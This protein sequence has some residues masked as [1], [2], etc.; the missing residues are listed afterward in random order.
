LNSPSGISSRGWAG[1]G[2]LAAVGLFGCPRAA[3]PAD[4]V[5]L[6][7]ESPPETLDR[8][9]ALS[10]IAENLSGNLLEPGLVR[11][12]DHG[13]PVPDLAE[14]FE[15]LD[16][17]TYLFTLRPGLRFH[18]GSP[19]RSADVVASFESLLDPR[20]ASPLAV[21]FQGLTFTAVGDLQVRVKLAKPYAPFLVDMQMGIVPARAQAAPGRDDFGQHPIGAGPFRF[22]SWVDEERLLLEA[23]PDYYGG[24]PAIAHL[25][26]KTVRDETTRVLEL[27]SG[28]ADIAINAISPPLLPELE[29][30]PN[31]RVLSTPGADVLFLMFQLT[32][33]QVADPRV[34]QALA[35]AIDRE[36]LIRYKFFGHAE[37]ADSL[38]PPASWAHA[39]GLPVYHRDLAK[40][41]ALLD[42]A[43]FPARAGA[44]R[45]TL[46]YKTS[47]DRFRKSI[48]LAIAQQL[49]EV[50][51]EVRV[52]TLE[53]GTFFS[54]IR[55]GSFELASM[56]WVPIVEP[57]LLYWVFDSASIPTPENGYNG[58]N[59][60][61]FR[62]P[63]LDGWLEAARAEPTEAARA[64]TYGKAQA[65]LAEELPYFVLWNEDSVAVVR[66]DL[67]GF[68]L[69]PYGYFDG[70]A[71]ARRIPP[72]VAR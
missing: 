49:A 55:K 16:A 51:V 52:Q 9:L 38:L 33:P 17:T 30:V 71:Q 37:L 56:K 21:K 68:H 58:G 53:F 63:T 64:V 7:V 2:L 46:T 13:R 40:A 34:R 50:G 1:I 57:D 45:L 66:R 24:R 18:D 44:P 47:T 15:Q 48:A 42:A 27:R 72:P 65:L 26:V 59:R 25:L 14:K 62:N 5:V 11:I 36:A 10:S 43:G 3:L 69:S 32:D 6:L 28:H 22:V 35:Y 67:E 54:D 20:L 39:A 70:L 8:R 29:G 31:L 19:L 23:N 12:D 41:R 60:E 4:A 61:R